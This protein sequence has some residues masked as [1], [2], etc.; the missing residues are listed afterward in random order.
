MASSTPALLIG[1]GLLALVGVTL[2]AAV[3]VLVVVLRRNRR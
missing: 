2:V 3:I 1:F